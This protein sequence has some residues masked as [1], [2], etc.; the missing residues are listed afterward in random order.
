MGKRGPR[1]GS[2]LL[3]PHTCYVCKAPISIEEA[4]NMDGTIKWICKPCRA[5][6]AYKNI[7]KRKSLEAVNRGINRLDKLREIL[8]SITEA[9]HGSE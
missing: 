1:K 5:D 7:W 6:V 8:I 9:K 3:V 4:Y 2:K